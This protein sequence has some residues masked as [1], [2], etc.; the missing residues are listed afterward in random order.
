MPASDSMPNT[1]PCQQKPLGWGEASGRVGLAEWPPKRGAWP[2][3]QLEDPPGARCVAA[4][5]EY[6]NGWVARA[7]VR[8]A[9]RVAVADRVQS[10]CVLG[11]R[12]TPGRVMHKWVLWG[13]S[14]KR[15]DV[16]WSLLKR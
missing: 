16:L 4:G 7:T 2:S 8:L 5:P 3:A 10:L 1:Y 9:V 15:Q 12:P 6:A 11:V 14:G 13:G